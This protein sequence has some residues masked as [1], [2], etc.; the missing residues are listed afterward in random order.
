MGLKVG[1]ESQNVDLRTPPNAH[2]HGSPQAVS[3]SLIC[4]RHRGRHEHDLPPHLEDG[5]L[6][7]CWAYGF[8]KK[9][10]PPQEWN[11]I[12]QQLREVAIMLPG[13]DVA[14]LGLSCEKGKG[15]MC[16]T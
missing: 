12:S 6:T 10:R 11:D 8:D 15:M 7:A 2:F 9:N 14:F 4:L 3:M 1:H 13:M 16:Y 5:A